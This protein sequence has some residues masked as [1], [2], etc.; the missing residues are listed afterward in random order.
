M[1][2]MIGSSNEQGM[3]Y[4]CVGFEENL[5]NPMEEANVTECVDIIT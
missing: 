5:L 1:E 3:Q 2:N 4:R